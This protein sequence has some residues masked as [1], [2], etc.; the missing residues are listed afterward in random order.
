M[1]ETEQKWQQIISKL[2]LIPFIE[3]SLP[4]KYIPWCNNKMVGI[5]T[6]D[7]NKPDWENKIVMCYHIGGFNK[8]LRESFDKNQYSYA[9]YVDKLDDD[10]YEIISFTIPSQFLK[11]YK[12]ILQGQYSKLSTQIKDKI[13]YFWKTNSKLSDIVNQILNGYT[14]N[15]KIQPALNS[16]ILNLNHVPI[17]KG[18]AVKHLPFILY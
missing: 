12:L 13:R 3:D 10:T 17:E 9:N 7:T 16:C 6:G 4:T 5:F 8:E 2:F 15:Y 18:D 11:D 1:T 14:Q